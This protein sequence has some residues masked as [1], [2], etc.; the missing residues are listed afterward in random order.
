MTRA[1]AITALSCYVSGDLDSETTA[2]VRRWIHKDE[3]VA[4]LAAHVAESR[5]AIVGAVHL[6]APEG[7]LDLVQQ[8][9]HREEPPSRRWAWLA[10][11]ALMLL[12]PLGVFSTWPTPAVSDVYVTAHAMVSAP[13]TW[14]DPTDARALDAA[15]DYNEVPEPL[16]VVPSLA[17]I[18]LTTVGVIVLPGNPAGSAVIY[19]DAQG[20]LYTCQMWS[21][22]RLPA[23][24]EQGTAGGVPVRFA[25]ED[26]VSMVAYMMNGMLCVTTSER[27]VQE[28][29]ALID[30][31][32]TARR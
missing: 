21:G 29:V 14:L 9:E 28:L 24:S 20:R 12:L 1:D 25:R 17:H 22:D 4:A 27:P 26:G 15:F 23:L 7:L 8:P 11:A 32:L 2:E 10:L 31:R 16:R 6:T 30:R 18:G 19:E 5:R 13:G 3:E